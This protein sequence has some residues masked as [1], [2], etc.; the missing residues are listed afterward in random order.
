MHESG[1]VAILLGQGDGTFKTTPISA[2]SDPTSVAIGDAAPG[3][4]GPAVSVGRVR[5]RLLGIC[6]PGK[7]K[8]SLG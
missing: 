7:V 4:V 5:K 6:R 3:A 1:G 2:G 8:P